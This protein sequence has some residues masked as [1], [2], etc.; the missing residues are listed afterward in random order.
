MLDRIT[1]LLLTWNEAPNIVRTLDR[2]AWARRIVVIDSGSTDATLDILRARPNVEVLSRAFDD[3]ATQWNF[4]LD[5]L[6]AP[7]AEWVLALDADYVLSEALVDELRSLTPSPDVAGYR[8]SFRYCIDGKL[9]HGSLY[10]PAIVLFRRALARFQQDG[11]CY[12]VALASGDVREL[13]APILHDDR[14]PFARWLQSQRRYAAE[15]AEK[16]RATP[17]RALRWPDRV[18]RVPFLAAPLVFGHC[19]VARGGW[20]DGRAG[21]AYAGQRAIAEA[22]ISAKL[23]ARG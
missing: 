15:E 19:L 21:L 2:L 18:R 14:K 6:D 5:A 11:H 17:W 7:D 1:P 20:R 22:M 12:R 16:L 8:A 23:L 13:T 9:L 3:F 10:P 4:G